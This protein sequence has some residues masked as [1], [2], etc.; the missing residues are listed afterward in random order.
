MPYKYFESYCVVQMRM[1]NEYFCWGYFFT[2]KSTC[3]TSQ[4][5]FG[6]RKVYCVSNVTFHAESKYAI[7]I[8]PSPT[9]FFTMAFL[10]I[11]F[12]EFL[13][14]SSVMFLYMNKY[15]KWFWTEGGHIQ[16]TVIISLVV[17]GQTQE[18]N[19]IMRQMFIHGALNLERLGRHGTFKSWALCLER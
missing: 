19:E 13:V 15:F 2:M 1:K 14:F 11:D 17:C 3:Y 12:S 9:V 10:I 7:K 16:F 4:Q 6:T 18:V 8:F 5:D